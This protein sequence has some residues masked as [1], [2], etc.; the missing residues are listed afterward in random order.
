ML[1][2]V[3][4]RFAPHLEGLQPMFP[5]TRRR[6][7]SLV[8]TLVVITILAALVGLLLPA[9]QKAREAALRMKS[10]NQLRQ[11]T[12]ALHHFAAANEGA[13]PGVKS[14][15]YYPLGDREHMSPLYSVLPYIDGEPS[16]L[17]LATD[18]NR[19]P[20]WRW[21][22][23][24]MSPA[25]PSL[26]FLN[27]EDHGGYMPSSYAAN[28]VAFEQ[29]PSL[30]RSFPDGMSN[31]LAYAERYCLFPSP[32]RADEVLFCA[33][34]WIP[35]T[36]GVIGGPRRA[37]F[38]DAGWKDVLPVTSGKPPVTHPSVAGVTFQVR[39][40]F[41]AADQHQ[42]QALY[43]SGLLVAFFDGSVRTLSPSIQE[44]V[45]W[46]LVTPS[47]GEVANDF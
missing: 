1:P 26:S 36:F 23:I 47:G 18:P 25:D 38:A 16:D 10:A 13:L 32:S 27:V 40:L 22:P 37:T 43:S 7:I 31:T 35:A 30:P 44:T 11:I 46:A 33:Q 6:G 20:T 9:V 42:L 8:E 15:T 24:F 28:M 12:L 14:A 34:D 39:P 21:R 29:F 4:G 41:R 5:S 19:P 2:W 17:A 3:N 45:F